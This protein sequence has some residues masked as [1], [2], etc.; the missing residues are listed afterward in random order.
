MEFTRKATCTL[1]EDLTSNDTFL[2]STALVIGGAGFVGSNL[3]HDL[4]RRG[5]GHLYIIDNFMSSEPANLP[6]DDRVHFLYG[7]A[8]DPRVLQQLPSDIDYVWHLAC[9]HG[10][11]SSIA[12]P[13]ADHENNTMPSLALFDHLSNYPALKK[14]VYAAAGCAVA[15]KTYGE[16][17]A[18][19]ED[20]PISL[21]H[22]SPYSISKL[23]GE[24]Y[25]NFYW[26]RDSLPF[27]RARFQNVYGPREILGA[28]QWR[29]TP[30]TVWRN[31]VP[32][33]IWRALNDLPLR[34]D[35]GGRASRDFIYVD[36]IV[37][38]LEVLALKGSPGEAYNL[39][40]GNET[41]ILKLAEI[42]VK[43]TNSNSELL[44]APAREWDRS[45]RRFGSTEKV[46]LQLGFE[47]SISLRDG[48]DVTATWMQANGAIIESCMA[49]HQ[50]LL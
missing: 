28:G 14:V 29:R 43:I 50:T 10:N 39:A 8:A 38:G 40:S 18:T 27:V 11:Q 48:L 15:E 37:R 2:G 33:F 9:Y 12:D 23:V 30:E 34:L 35:N 49:R 26:I 1:G 4:L 42:I 6:Q 5:V 13:F 25:G 24:L 20:A 44:V 32:T 7:S 22:D 45:G 41:E 31:V 17:S 16:A 47:A 46:R 21:F 3:S 36:D 19:A